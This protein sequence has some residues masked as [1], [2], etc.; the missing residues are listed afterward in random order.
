MV[1]RVLLLILSLLPTLSLAAP[2]SFDQAKRLAERVYSIHP[3]SF[4]CGC[5]IT[6]NRS[7]TDIPDL[8]GC[9][10]KI[11]KNGPRA[12]RIEWEHVMPAYDFGRQRQCWQNGGRTNCQKNDPV[13]RAME[14]DM[15]N[16]VPAIG[17]VNGDRSNYRFGMIPGQPTQY[18]TCP[19]KI[20]FSGRT[21]EPRDA[22]KGD[23]AR[24]YFYMADRYN[25]RLSDQQQRLFSAWDRLDPV[26]D[27]ERTRD[28]R[29]GQQMGHRNPF[30]TGAKAW[31]ME[32]GRAS[33]DT[34]ATSQPKAQSKAEPS[35]HSGIRGNKNSR[36]YHRPDCPSYGAV[37]EKN[38]VEFRSAHEA[39]QAGYRIAG[40]CRP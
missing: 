38:R 34:P 22:V 3:E 2:S 14:A 32:K 16:L 23:V 5:K 25:L 9:G 26:D 28:E 20:D 24:I 18:G 30:V 4:Y 21:V 8:Q 1:I 39:E 17:E 6:W 12:N 7:G 15:H 31:S 13:F 40:N 37:S 10:Y 19:V 29:I 35:T 33:T 36:V 27:W 11:R